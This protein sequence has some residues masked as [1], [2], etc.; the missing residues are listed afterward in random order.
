[1]LLRH[2]LMEMICSDEKDLIM[3]HYI[4]AVR[5]RLKFPGVSL[6]WIPP[7]KLWIPGCHVV[8]H[9][10]AQVFGAKAVDGEHAYFKGR[11]VSETG[12]TCI[13][14][15]TYAHSWNILEIND[16]LSLILDIYP[17]IG[18]PM[19]PVL[20]KNPHPAYW[21]P[22]D[23][24][25]KRQIVKTLKESEQFPIEVRVVAEAFQKIGSVGS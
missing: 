21:V 16:N 24:L 10:Y 6:P 13:D 20:L 8:A 11:E 18:C 23:E 2:D 15:S 25:F 22:T 1:M 5:L 9:A 17:D 4:R 7:E 12:Q 3:E 14:L 19:M